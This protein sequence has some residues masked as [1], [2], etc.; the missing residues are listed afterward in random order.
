[1]EE[2]KL[3][4]QDLKNLQQW[5]RSEQMKKNAY[6]K[7]G[8]ESIDQYFQKRSEERLKRLKDQ[9]SETNQYLDLKPDMRFLKY[10]ENFLNN[11]RY[12]EFNDKLIS[13]EKFNTSLN[14]KSRELLNGTN[15]SDIYNYNNCDTSETNTFGEALGK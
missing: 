6:K 2:R 14:I 5:K 3:I 11:T 8:Q 7:I 1:M 10:K 4:D 15:Q 13:K 12:Q 9:S